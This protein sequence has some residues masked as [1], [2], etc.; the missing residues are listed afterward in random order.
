M[1]S[2]TQ[3]KK[4]NV[5]KISIFLLQALFDGF[6][7]NYIKMSDSRVDTSYIFYINLEKHT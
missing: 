7:S 4:I 1:I 3:A 6:V 2:I 5:F